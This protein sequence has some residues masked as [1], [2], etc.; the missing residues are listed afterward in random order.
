M[1]RRTGFA[2]GLRLSITE[3]CGFGYPE[4]LKASVPGSNV[5]EAQFEHAPAIGKRLRDCRG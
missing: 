3:S 4:A 2:T 1:T 5:I